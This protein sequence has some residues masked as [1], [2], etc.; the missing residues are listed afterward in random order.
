MSLYE[1]V[2]VLLEQVP[3]IEALA[4]QEK[5]P[6]DR[7]YA[8]GIEL[9]ALVNSHYGE[10]SHFHQ[11]VTHQLSILQGRRRVNQAWGILKGIAESLRKD[12]DEK[13]SRDHRRPLGW[14]CDECSVSDDVRLVGRYTDTP[15]RRSLRRSIPTQGKTVGVAGMLLCD[16]C[17]LKELKTPPWSENPRLWSSDDVALLVHS[18]AIT[19]KVEVSREG[20]FVNGQVYDAF[21]SIQC[22]LETAH[23]RICLID[24]YLS[25]ETFDILAAK[26]T[27]V[28]VLILAHSPN[29]P[30]HVAAR[31]FAAQ[32]GP[33]S[34]HSTNIFH[35]RWL[36]I[37]DSDYYHFGTSLN[38]AGKRVFMFSKMEEQ[39]VIDA[40]RMKWDSEWAAS[41]EVPL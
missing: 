14:H 35:D 22:L 16:D 33:L 3:D 37:D 29:N 23:T 36:I 6:G 32:Y 30:T 27:G 8:W 9:L 38:Q 21:R 31:R 34:I 7:A 20:L 11:E 10:H 39:S 28:E 4:E 18:S 17:R 2:Q 40:L 1:R 25:V 24:A 12:L 15:E 5:Y 19:P 41:Q 26:P 13:Y